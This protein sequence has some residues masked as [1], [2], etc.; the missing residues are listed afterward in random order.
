MHFHHVVFRDAVTG[1]EY[2]VDGV[3]D[4]IQFHGEFVE[5]VVRDAGNASSPAGGGMEGMGRA[6]GAPAIAPPF[7]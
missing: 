4:D 2:F 7:E 3:D 1:T 6:F 5:W